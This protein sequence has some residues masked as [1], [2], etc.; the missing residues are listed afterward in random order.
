MC[1]CFLHVWIYGCTYIST[2]MSK[3]L[4]KSVR[5]WR[6]FLCMYFINKNYRTYFNLNRHHLHAC[7]QA[8]DIYT[9]YYRSSSP[10]NMRTI[11]WRYDVYR[12][13]A[14]PP[15]FTASLTA[16][17]LSDSCMCAH[18]TPFLH[19]GASAAISGKLW[20]RSLRLHERVCV[21]IYAYV[22]VKLW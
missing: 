11:M 1:V 18:H 19:L 12:D 17:S 7:M 6:K 8:Y 15:E 5:V 13:L 2:Y 4:R 3:C 21:F 9:R 10:Y 22:Y 14:T 16:H 20:Y